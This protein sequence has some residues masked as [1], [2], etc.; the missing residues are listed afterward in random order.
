MKFKIYWT[1]IVLIIHVS[2]KEVFHNIECCKSK[3]ELKLLFWPITEHANSSVRPTVCYMTWFYI[4]MAEYVAQVF[5]TNRRMFK[6]Q[7]QRKC[8]SNYFWHSIENHFVAQN[9][10]VFTNRTAPYFYFH[11][12][13]SPSV[14]SLAPTWD[15]FFHRQQGIGF[16]L[17]C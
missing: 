6:M 17:Q 10:H 1:Q 16:C 9:L 3:T 13:I 11:I 7:N 4:K 5:L 12:R 14:T 8:M 2:F 15:G